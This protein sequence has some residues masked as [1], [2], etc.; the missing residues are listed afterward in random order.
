[1]DGVSTA[2]EIARA[3]GFSDPPRP[4][5]SDDVERMWIN[6]DRR[7]TS[8]TVG[9]G[10]ERTTISDPDR[11][12]IRITIEAAS[13]SGFEPTPGSPVPAE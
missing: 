13:A 10:D 4:L 1:V 7:G 12:L 11:A 3:A 6:L 5:V 2:K 8:I 9:S